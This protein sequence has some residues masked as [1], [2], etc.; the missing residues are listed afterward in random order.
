MSLNDIRLENDILLYLGTRF[1]AF[2]EII[3]KIFGTNDIEFYGT[4]YDIGRYY[5]GN[6]KWFPRRGR[7]DMMFKNKEMVVPV[8]LKTTAN[9][10]GYYQLE[11][12]M[13]VL[14][15]EENREVNGI[16]LCYSATKKLKEMK[17]SNNIA[18]I[19]LST[20]KVW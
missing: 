20:G 15:Q 6:S 18:I 9:I 11:N 2:K 14:E 5:G 8:E 17:I 10:D 4:E 1:D 3:N 12:Y 19:E 13:N 7:V 16:L